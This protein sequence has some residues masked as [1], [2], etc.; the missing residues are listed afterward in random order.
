MPFFIVLTTGP[1]PQRFSVYKVQKYIL[2]PQFIT[3]P[4]SHITAPPNTSIIEFLMGLTG[5]TILPIMTSRT[6]FCVDGTNLERTF[7]KKART[8]ILNF[9][10]YVLTY[11]L[12]YVLTEHVGA[13]HWWQE[14]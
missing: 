9:L 14:R 4:Y 8:T 5:G 6:D 1:H 10:L 11:L 12:T 3:Q 2:H 13:C 7:A